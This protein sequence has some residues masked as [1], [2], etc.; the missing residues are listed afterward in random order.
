MAS[1][2]PDTCGIAIL[3]SRGVPLRVTLDNPSQSLTNSDMWSFSTKNWQGYDMITV[4]EIWRMAWMVYG[5]VRVLHPCQNI[6]MKMKMTE[7][8][9][10]AGNEFHSNNVRLRECWIIDENVF[11]GEMAQLGLRCWRLQAEGVSIDE[12][13]SGFF[14]ESSDYFSSHLR[15]PVYELGVQKMNNR[16]DFGIYERTIISRW[17]EDRENKNR[18][19]KNPSGLNG[20]PPG[21]KKAPKF[22]RFARKPWSSFL[23]QA[24]LYGFETEWTGPS[25][26]V[27][28]STPEARAEKEFT[29]Q[30]CLR[31]DDFL[32]KSAR[33]CQL[34]RLFGPGFSSD[35]SGDGPASYSIM[36]RWRKAR[37]KNNGSS[38]SRFAELS[39]GR[40]DMDMEAAVLKSRVH[41]LNLSER[42]FRRIARMMRGMG[43]RY[44]FEDFLRLGNRLC[45]E[46]DPEAYPQSEFT[47]LPIELGPTWQNMKVRLQ[48]KSLAPEK[49]EHT[50]EPA[51]SGDTVLVPEVETIRDY[52]VPGAASAPGDAT[53]FAPESDEEGQPQ[54]GNT[55]PLKRGAWSFWKRGW[56][57][58]RRRKRKK[59]SS[60]RRRPRRR[61]RRTPFC[62][63]R[64]ARLL[65]R[66]IGGLEG[67]LAY[68]A[69]MGATKGYG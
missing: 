18:H 6:G 41:M 23:S 19:L 39:N 24:V 17:D 33:R 40:W 34:V 56:K 63:K 2:N 51:V 26:D 50:S 46:C 30:P 11:E 5:S 69:R 53:S 20:R 42:Q 10:F 43:E 13:L 12:Q 48:K 25:R 52:Q 55:P 62:R 32:T 66:N 44:S 1:R 3:C 60:K 57:V 59:R 38:W 45:R 65:W 15:H 68:V 64:V 22:S 67:E 16:E 35:N 29:F 36:D 47:G 61:R 9:K 4:T 37:R 58:M 54:M 14:W 7:M 8:Q 49:T 27:I 31:D 28:D 21:D